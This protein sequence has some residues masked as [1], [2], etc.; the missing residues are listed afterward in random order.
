MALWMI[1]VLVGLLKLPLVAL[2]LWMPFR[3]D[4]PTGE[5]PG[6]SSQDDGGSKVAPGSPRDP[7]PRR[8]LPHLPRRG[9]HGASPTPPPRMRHGTRGPAR[10]LVGDLRK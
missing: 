4:D 2:L 1:F 10:R 5:P 3:E 9:P 7:H 6:S 8:P